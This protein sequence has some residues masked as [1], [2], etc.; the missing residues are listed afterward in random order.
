[1]TSPL[2]SLSADKI[3]GPGYE[4]QR[5]NGAYIVIE[6]L[7]EDPLKMAIVSFPIPKV[8]NNAVEVHHG[9]EVRKFAGKPTFE[10]LSI[11]MKDYIES[12][13]L[14]KLL[15]WRKKVYNHETGQI[16]WAKDYKK[17]GYIYLHG[18]DG[19]GVRKWRIQGAWPSGFDPGDVDHSSDDTTQITMTLTIDKAWYEGK[20]G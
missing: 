3:G 2:D 4:P 13:L 20:Q 17:N 9:N 15:E 10:D 8:T 19:N 11:V 18:P 16:G 14:D 6:G 5:Q 1:M 7:D 12:P